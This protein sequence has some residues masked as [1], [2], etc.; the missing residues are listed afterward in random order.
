LR[1][2]RGRFLDAL[3]DIVDRQV[4]HP[5]LGHAIELRRA[6]RKDATHDIITQLGNPIRAVRHRHRLEGPADGCAI[7][8]L[9]LLRVPGHQLIP[10]EMSMGPH[11]SSPGFAITDYWG[12]PR[13]T[14]MC[15]LGLI[16]NYRAE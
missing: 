3:V 15:E 12:K 10:M 4:G 16:L 8:R 6:Q 11:L 7:E 1:A 14:T 13:T 2:C 5:L 9:C